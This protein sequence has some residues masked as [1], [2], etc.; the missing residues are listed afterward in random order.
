MCVVHTNTH[1][2]LHTHICTL[3]YYIAIKRNEIL[4]FATT[5]TMEGFVLSEISQT[6]KDKYFMLSHVKSEK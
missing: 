3:D 2:Y 4:P 5:C 6:E 1:T